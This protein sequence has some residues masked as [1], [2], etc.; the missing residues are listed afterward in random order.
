MEQGKGLAILNTLRSIPLAC[1]TEYYYSLSQSPDICNASVAR[2]C[3]EI[4]SSN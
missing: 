4:I 1:N 3:T 2:V